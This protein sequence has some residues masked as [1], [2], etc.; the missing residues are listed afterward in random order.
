MQHQRDFISAS[1]HLTR[2]NGQIQAGAGIGGDVAVGPVQQIAVQITDQARQCQR[3]GTHVGQGHIKFD[4]SQ[5]AGQQFKR[6]GKHFQR[7]IDNRDLIDVEI[8]RLGDAVNQSA[9]L[10]FD[11]ER[12]LHVRDRATVGHFLARPQLA[13]DF[14]TRR[15]RN[16]LSRHG[17]SQRRQIGVDSRLHFHS[18]QIGLAG[19]DDSHVKDGVLPFDQR[20]AHLRIGRDIDRNILQHAHDGFGIIR[21]LRLRNRFQSLDN[22]LV[23]NARLNVG[24]DTG[25]SLQRFARLYFI[26]SAVAIG[27]VRRGNLD[28][29]QVDAARIFDGNGKDSRITLGDRL[30]LRRHGHLDTWIDNRHL[31]DGI[32]AVLLAVI[33]AETDITDDGGVGVRNVGIDPERHRLQHFFVIS[34]GVRPAQG[35]HPARGAETLGDIRARDG[36]VE[37][38]LGAMHA[39]HDDDRRPFHHGIINV[40]DGN[41]LAGDL[42]RR[43]AGDESGAEARTRSITVQIQRGRVILW[44]KGDDYLGR[45]RIQVPI[46]ACPIELVLTG[47]KFVRH[48][49]EIT[50]IGGIDLLIFRHIPGTKFKRAVGGQGDDLDF[51]QRIAIYVG[52]SA[53]K[54]GLL[55]QHIHAFRPANLHI[56]NDWRIVDGL[57]RNGYLRRFRGVGRPVGGIP[58]ERSRA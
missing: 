45:G 57:H 27:H 10:D 55:K 14:I 58:V 32:V 28:I 9:D 52:K 1:P 53:G 18:R 6:H 40:S 39:V 23:V 44:R 2:G 24:N 35:Q 36:G 19:V 7:H 17:Y 20:T 13:N 46:G 50:E 26:E 38:F 25:K 30:N 37:D 34:D 54:V 12:G 51:D 42:H 56:G 22:D 11:L 49:T 5:L 48:I 15:R 21:N 3:H 33:N 31:G 4:G 29:R 43:L 47:V 16:R 8:R 41:T